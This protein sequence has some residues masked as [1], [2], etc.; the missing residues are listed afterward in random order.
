MNNSELVTRLERF[1]AANRFS[2]ARKSAQA[3]LIGKQYL[4]SGILSR[5]S[6]TTGYLR[7][8]RLRQG[9]TII[10]QLDDSDNSLSI[11]CTRSSSISLAD[12][13]VSTP[14]AIT[15][16]I[17]DYDEVRLL[18]EAEEVG[19]DNPSSGTGEV[20]A[21]AIDE[22]QQTHTASSSE[23]GI[24]L[25]EIQQMQM[26]SQQRLSEAADDIIKAQSRNV[27][28]VNPE[29]DNQDSTEPLDLVQEPPA[30]SPTEKPSLIDTATPPEVKESII[31]NVPHPKST[32]SDKVSQS[33]EA[34]TT[35][36][37]TRVKPPL[38]ASTNVSQQSATEGPRIAS[39]ELDVTED[40]ETTTINSRL[41]QLRR[42]ILD[43][44]Q[45]PILQKDFDKIVSLETGVPIEKVKEIQKHLWHTVMSPTMFGKEREIFNFFPFGDFRL[46]RSRDAVNMDFK[47]APV[48][49]LAKH[50]SVEEYPHSNF[51]CS[52]ADSNHP[53]IATQ[54]IRIAATVGPLVGL[55]PPVTYDVIFETLQLLLKVF[56]VGK[57]RIRFT[58]VGEFFPVVLRGTIQY[59]FRPYR[60]LIRFATESFRAIIS[61]AEREGEGQI[62][63]KADKGV[64]DRPGAT[65]G[66]SPPVDHPKKKK[67]S[68]LG[69][70]LLGLAF[71]VFRLVLFIFE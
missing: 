29:P 39:G 12:H 43:D 38:K 52:D 6:N 5:V 36:V 8:Q 33:E 54:A 49:Q 18:L 40:I 46:M 60:P 1:V 35:S 37:P 19:N 9:K 14:L 10:L 53:P 11:R 20:T 23:N 15:V 63:F 68:Q 62:A 27:P 22:S 47:S 24:I 44:Q 34:V 17:T 7:N 61:L 65:R 55:S 51:D 57:R 66:Y 28:L 58:D 48:P 4:V 30:Q 16:T 3:D 13:D 26:E 2:E 59:H 69:C 64:P 42:K 56:G 67:N 32:A 70:L 21:A 50:D 45:K 41:D 31:A 25:D 71:L